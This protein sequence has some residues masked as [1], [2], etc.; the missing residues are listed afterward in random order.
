MPHS[1]PEL[2]SRLDVAD[3]CGTA[4]QD[5]GGSRLGRGLRLPVLFEVDGLRPKPGVVF[6]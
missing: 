2:L 1:S 6:G 4:H 5:D 3:G